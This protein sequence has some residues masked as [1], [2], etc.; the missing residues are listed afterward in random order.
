M[1]NDTLYN[2]RIKKLVGSEAN[3]EVEKRV[4]D[5][6]WQDLARTFISKFRGVRRVSEQYKQSVEGKS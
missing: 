1:K 3:E 6:D 2:A 4:P 5:G